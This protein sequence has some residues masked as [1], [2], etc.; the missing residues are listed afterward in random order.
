MRV[1]LTLAL[2][3][4]LLTSACSLLPCVERRDASGLLIVCADRIRDMPE[5]L[6]AAGSFAWELAEAHPDVFGYPWADPDTGA[7]ELR[8]TGSGADAF[9]GEWLAGT[10][11]RGTGDKTLALP[12]PEVPVRRATVDRSVRQLT[13]IMNA[14]TPPKGLP[15]ADVVWMAGPDLR[16]NAIVVGIDHESDALLRALAARYGTS[17]IVI[18][19]ERRPQTLPL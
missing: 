7:V 19:I 4:S 14:V 15:D 16:R 1:A 8:V 10:A 11:T 5:A 6:K 17:A 13:E 3:V 2:F 9:I 18:H 12:R